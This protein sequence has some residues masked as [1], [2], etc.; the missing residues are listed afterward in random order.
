[1]QAIINAIKNSSRYQITFKDF[2]EIA[3]YDTEYGY[4]SKGRRKIGKEG[5]FYTSSFVHPVFAQV[6]ASFFYTQSKMNDIKPTICEIGGGDGRFAKAVLDEWSE[7]YPESY[8]QLRYIIIEKSPYHQEEIRSKLKDHACYSLYSDLHAAKLEY[9]LMEGIIFSNELL[10]ALPVHLV[11]K[12]DDSLFEVFVT[13]DDQNQ[14]T[15]KLVPCVNDEIHNWLEFYGVPLGNGQ[16]FE[17]PLSMMNWIEEISNWL[18]KGLLVTIDYGYKHEDWCK[19]EHR[20]GSI[21]GYF[22]HQL[23]RDPL[24]HPGEMDLT[25]HI[26]ID[27]FIQHGKKHDLACLYENIQLE[28]LLAAG[29]LSFLQD[30][31]DPNPFSEISR[32]N[33]A[34]RTFITPGG[35]SSSFHV[36]IQGKRVSKLNLDSQNLI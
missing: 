8:E 18:N 7:R 12:K 34:I 28:F 1:M 26:H 6:F 17:I 22:K 14:F 27:P 25:T 32:M 13:L 23:V 20:D 30:H 2:M 5:D 11:E 24:K 3:L 16:R 36:I 33:R 10:D 9:P 4:Y 31:F 21:R 15:E 19:R 35:I 29:I